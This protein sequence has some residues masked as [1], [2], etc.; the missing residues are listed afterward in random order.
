MTDDQTTPAPVEVTQADREAAENALFELRGF[1]TRI[2]SDKHCVVQAF[3]RHRIAHSAPAG[4]VVAY[5]ITDADGGYWFTDK[6][7]NPDL[8]DCQITQT[9]LYAHPPPADRGGR[10]GGP[11]QAGKGADGGAAAGNSRLRRHL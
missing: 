1:R 4:E 8:F 7:E 9:P 6:P 5:K 3:A 2:A 11:S 10:R